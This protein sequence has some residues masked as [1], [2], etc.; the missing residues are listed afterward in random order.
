[1]RI[2]LLI[3]LLALNASGATYWVDFDGGSDSNTGTSSAS[4][5]KHCRGDANAT[6]VAGTGSLAA[7]DT[8]NFK[9]GVYY[10]GKISTYGG[11]SGSR[12]TYQGNSAVHGWGTGKAIIDGT[13]AVSW[14]VC[15]ANGTNATEVP[16]AN[17]ASMYYG[18][19]PGGADHL[20]P[21]LENNTYM[22]LATSSTNNPSGFNFDNTDYYNAISSGITTT[23]CTDAAYFTQSDSNYWVGAYIYWHVAGSV[24]AS[25]ITSFNPSTDTVGYGAGGAP[26]QDNNWD[27]K[28]H[29]QVV[30]SPRLI[31][32]A[33][34]YA[35]DENRGLIF[36]WPATSASNV[37][38]GSE[39]GAFEIGGNEYVTIDGFETTGHYG[40][41][42]FG[43]IVRT[44]NSTGQNGVR[45][46]NC[47]F[48]NAA[49]TLGNLPSGS[50]YIRGGGSELSYV[51]NCTYRFIHG[52]GA[53]VTGVL[54]AVKDCY[55]D[56]IDRTAVYTQ[57]YS[58]EDNT[59]IEFSG[60]I[61]TNCYGVHMNGITGYGGGTNF[62]IRLVIR[63]NKIYNFIQRQGPG[64]ITAQAFKD[65]EISGNLVEADQGMPIDGPSPGSTYVKIFNNTVVIPTATQGN[66]SAGVIRIYNL[67]NNTMLYF[68]NNI[69]AGLV[70]ADEGSSSGIS[71]QRVAHDNNIFTAYTSAQ[72]ALKGWTNGPNESTSTRS[73]LFNLAT[74][75]DYSL[76]A[77]GPAIDTGANMTSAGLTT[78]ANKVAWTLPY[79]MGAFQFASGGGGGGSSGA[80]RA[81]MNGRMVLQ[82]KVV[83]Q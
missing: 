10:R 51:S 26:Y 82:G 63:N 75:S 17:F 16:N 2:L 58:G 4:P 44:T 46:L 50:T 73:A 48:K 77:G 22:D 47:D 1:M 54:T 59:D 27:A 74:G 79:D 83:V 81:V 72:T 14:S 69:S 76:K 35:V 29:Y 43:R 61:V 23:S 33:G 8:V 65:L 5:W 32:R 37:R 38:V 28:Y 31:T 34:Q 62:C 45:I 11:T 20:I 55:F 42:A 13:A 9:G 24:A 68:S 53:F 57:N 78:D 36:I 6:G 56:T 18:A 15:T 67:T 41:Y 60:N 40:G 66:A 30:S 52:R 71:W 3:L 25:K 21:V 64:G 19:L 39:N 80:T 7:G 70:I 12:I 49:N